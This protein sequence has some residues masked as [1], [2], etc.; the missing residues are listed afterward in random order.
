MKRPNVDPSA[1]N[2]GAIMAASLRGNVECARLLLRD[3]RV[4]ADARTRAL[5]LAISHN[6]YQLVELLLKDELADPTFN[7]NKNIILASSRGY[8]GIV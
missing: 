5:E 4:D 2:N 3:E 1:R 7:S 8:N 6:H